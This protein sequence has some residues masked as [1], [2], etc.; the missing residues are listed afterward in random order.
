MNTALALV[1]DR[2]WKVRIEPDKSPQCHYR[3][4][5]FLEFTVT[6][7]GTPLLMQTTVNQLISFAPRD[8]LNLSSSSLE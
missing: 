2:Q 8:T 1:S 6:G 4:V 5:E 7:A 3:A